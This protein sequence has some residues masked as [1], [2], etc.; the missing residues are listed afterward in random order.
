MFISSYDELIAAAKQQ[1]EPQRLLFVFT[2]VQ[3]PEEHSESEAQ[4]FRDGQAGNLVPV[5][6]VDIAIDELGS[7]AHL[8]AESKQTGKDWK[9]V[10]VACL[11]GI[12]G[13][14]P[15]SSDAETPLQTMQTNILSGM[16]DRYLAYDRDGQQIRFA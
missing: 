2:Q 7:F 6:C 16:V 4:R 3:L 11:D 13:Q 14:L 12:N 10:F 9:I 15:S 8:V 5:F 1:P